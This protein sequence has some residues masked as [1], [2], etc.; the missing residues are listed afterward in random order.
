MADGWGPPAESGGWGPPA[1][2]TPTSAPPEEETT[3]PWEAI[4]HGLRAGLSDV[5]QT[6]QVAQGQ[7]PQ[8]VPETGPETKPLEWGDVASPYSQ[9]LPKL[10]YQLGKGSPTIAG[11]IAGGALGSAAGAGPWGTLA[12]GMGGAAVGA[13]LQEVGPSFAQELQKS[14]NDPDGAWTKALEHTGIAAAGSA[15]GWGLF[16]ARFFNG[17]VKNLA[18]QVLGVQPAVA[19]GEHAAQN[20]VSGQPATEGLGEAYAQGVAST[21]VPMAGHA[22]LHAILPRAGEVPAGTRTTPEGGPET[23]TGE[24]PSPINPT[25]FVDKAGKLIDSNFGDIIQDLQMKATPM[26]ANSAS[27]DARALAKDFANQK[28]TSQWT[29]NFIDEA[30]TKYFTPEEREEMWTRADEES[31]A[32]QQGLPTEGIGLSQLSPNQKAMVEA[33]QA[34]A[35]QSWQTATDLGMVKGE[36]LPSYTPRIFM[37]ATE[38][39]G[40]PASLTAIGRNLRT[41]TGQMKQRK[42]MTA[43]ETEAAG[44]ETL[45]D[46]AELVRDIR[47][48]PYATARMQEA[49]AGRTLINRIKEV[50]D[51][52]GE[53][54]VSENG[55]PQGTP[56]KWF[57]V[58]HPS[59]KTTSPRFKVDPET[60]T[61]TPVKDENGNLVFDKKPLYV[62]SDFEGPLKAVLSRDQ[63]RVYR[64]LMDL[65]GKTMSVIMYSPLIHNAVEWGR[66]LPAMPGKVAFFRIY[67]EGNAAK[68]NPEMMREAV[69][70]GLV[71]IGHRGYMQDIT[72]MMEEPHLAPG[73]SWTSQIAGAIPGFFS[74]TAGDAVKRSIDKMGD[75]WHNTLLWDRVADL[76]MGLYK[77]FMDDMLA[78]GIDRQSASRAASHLANRYAGALPLESMSESA[79]KIANLALFSRTFTLG[80][81]GAMKDMFTGLPRDVQ[82]QILRDAGPEGLGKIKGYAQKKAIATVLMDVGLM[83][84]GNSIIQDTVNYMR[85][86]QDLEQVAKG[87]LDRLS[88][89][90]Q[91]TREHPF[92]TL[93]HPF[94]AVESLSSTGEH[95]PGKRDRILVGYQPDGTAIYMRNPTGKIGEEMTG[96]MSGPFDMVKRKLGTIARPLSQIYSNDQGFGRKVYNPQAS[97]T[98]EQLE[99]VGNIVT[100]LMDSQVPMQQVQAAKDL[101]N[102]SSDAN[103]SRLKLLGPLAGLTF[104]QGAP[105]GPEMGEYFAAS[106]RHQYEVNQALP[107]IRRQIKAGN[108]DVARQTMSKLNIPWGLQNYY[109]KTTQNPSLRLSTRR[110]KDFLQYGTPEEKENFSRDRGLRP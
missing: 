44:K 25:G 101:Y 26:A 43:E 22:A 16:P 29:W 100:T 59:F 35:Q 108:I 109:I 17:P 75:I 96:W 66:A 79:R 103:T 69:G 104:S 91:R 54:T 23:P 8:A 28:R 105:G 93:R 62:R 67:F 15:A 94:S 83:Y 36:G 34:H 85:G 39:L 32:R 97:T 77:N 65:K 63:G 10:G 5:G 107:D 102:N 53:P 87:Y 70:N 30:L 46:Q 98:A 86:Q 76:Q 80:N 57:T 90:L 95:E 60:N 27:P 40:F 56:Y 84:A 19:V 71:P 3:S 50:G 38:A 99:N 72:S 58:D 45:G 20:V 6:A 24:A 81:L 82:A 51:N 9:L 42:Y 88:G 55:E 48:L 1:A 7:A 12:G 74:K 14:P 31:V 33:L 89:L 64:G 61:A 37:N 49:I 73:R 13:A 68:N 52:T 21:A 106:E 92:E 41:T 2:P 47:A 4:Y 110:Y 78:K 18:F 11:G